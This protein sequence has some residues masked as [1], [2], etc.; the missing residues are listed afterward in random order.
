MSVNPA[1]TK[2]SVA[3]MDND[4]K[5]GGFHGTPWE[6]N[7]VSMNAGALWVGGY[8]AI[9]GSDVSYA[10]EI[11]MA[12]TSD[13]TDSFEVHFVTSDRFIATKSG[14]LYRFGKRI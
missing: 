4:G 7:Q 11:L 10:C 6:F 2:W 1:G 5:I 3:P 13:P 14:K 8:R 9:P 12:N